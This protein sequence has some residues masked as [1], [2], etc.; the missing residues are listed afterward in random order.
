MSISFAA[1]RP[2]RLCAAGRLVSR[3]GNHFSN[4]VEV[5]E[6]NDGRIVAF[7]TV[8]YRIPEPR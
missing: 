7:G 4:Q 2:G 8:T 3:T 1:R 6:S 5:F